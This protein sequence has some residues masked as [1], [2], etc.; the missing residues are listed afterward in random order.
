M[1]WMRT[2][3]ISSA[4]IQAAAQRLLRFLK[5]TVHKPEVPVGECDE[6]TG[7]NPADLHIYCDDSKKAQAGRHGIIMMERRYDV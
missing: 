7:N 2:V 6:K 1:R 4:V 5:S 3:L